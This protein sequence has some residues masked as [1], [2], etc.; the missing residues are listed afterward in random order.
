METLFQALPISATHLQRPATASSFNFSGD[1]GNLNRALLGKFR[2]QS[3]FAHPMAK[4]RTKP[5]EHQLTGKTCTLRG[6]GSHMLG[7]L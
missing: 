2:V 1:V 4:R 5:A 7:E 6:S 3:T